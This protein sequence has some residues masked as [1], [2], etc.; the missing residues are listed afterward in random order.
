MTRERGIIIDLYENEKLVAVLRRHWLT[1]LNSII[2][3]FILIIFFI[4]GLF[5][6]Y[7][8]IPKSANVSNIPNISASNGLPIKDLGQKALVVLGT[9]YILSV[10]GYA[11]IV[12]FDYYL[13]IFVITD[14][15]IMRVEQ[16]VLFSQ[17]VSETSFQHVQDVS[18]QVKG[19]IGTL[20]NVGTIFIET[21][22][23]R[24]NFSFTY[25]RDPSAITATILELQKNMWDGEG[26]KGDLTNERKMEK[27]KLMNGEGF[28]GELTS[29]K[30]IE[31]TSGPK[32]CSKDE[33][34][35]NISPGIER[36]FEPEFVP[37][38]IKKEAPPKIE[39]EA[40]AEAPHYT[41]GRVVTSYGVI[42][43]SNQESNPD[44]IEALNGLDNEKEF[45]LKDEW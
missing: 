37:E 1:I 29:P 28:K 40:K 32:D 43:Q 22:G 27:I 36:Y 44:V 20:L 25:M 16:A 13:D 21:A 33:D 31:T 14:K 42:W 19:V 4:V 35:H 24:E 23:E 7:D 45:S 30:N 34:L 15:R 17:R 9:V 11:Y 12:W 26:F 6:S 39:E 38:E 18:S 2:V 10:L 5:Y 8:K 3:F 41:D